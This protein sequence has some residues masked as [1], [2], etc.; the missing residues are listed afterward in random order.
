MAVL[1]GGEI[2]G[3]MEVR[4]LLE[5]IRVYIYIGAVTVL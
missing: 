5:Y 4:L 2:G 3:A 1:E